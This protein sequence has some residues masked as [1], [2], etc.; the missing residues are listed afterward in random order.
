MHGL[1]SVDNLMTSVIRLNIACRAWLPRVDIYMIWMKHQRFWIS[2]TRKLTFIVGHDCLKTLLHCQ[3]IRYSLYEYL[4]LIC[5]HPT[6]FVMK[7]WTTYFNKIH[8]HFEWICHCDVTFDLW[9]AICWPFSQRFKLL[10]GIW[11]QHDFLTS[12][13]YKFFS[14]IGNQHGNIRLM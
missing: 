2:D 11:Y 12:L 13:Y 4:L 7:I 8:K 1:Q 6:V 3:G 5:V 10:V 14:I 9:P